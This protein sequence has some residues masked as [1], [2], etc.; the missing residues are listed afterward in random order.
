M[1]Y[2]SYMP[3]FGAHTGRTLV[4]SREFEVRERLCRC[5]SCDA[6]SGH[7]Y[8]GISPDTM[9]IDGDGQIHGSCGG[10][11]DAHVVCRI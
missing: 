11:G 10:A 8:V 4:V 2:T 5:M 7:P 3:S 1:D 6:A 9:D